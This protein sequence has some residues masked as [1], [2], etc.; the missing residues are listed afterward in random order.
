MESEL[1]VVEV[2]GSDGGTEVRRRAPGFGTGGG[3][4]QCLAEVGEK[5]EELQQGRSRRRRRTGKERQRQQEEAGGAS[6]VTLSG[7]AEEPPSPET[8]ELPQEKRAPDR[9]PLFDLTSNTHGS[10]ARFARIYRS[11]KTGVSTPS[12]PTGTTTLFPSMLPWM[13]P[14][15]KS[16]H[17]RGL[18][19]D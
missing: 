16:K 1:V 5:V 12:K 17:G 7:Q 3:I 18:Q 14:P 11:V 6:R 13:K 10:F 15:G 19:S 9:S 4:P 2:P 8:P